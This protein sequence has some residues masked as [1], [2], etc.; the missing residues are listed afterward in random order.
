MIGIA[1][2]KNPNIIYLPWMR[3]RILKVIPDYEDPP[4]PP[5]LKREISATHSNQGRQG[6]CGRHAFSRVIVKNFFELILP[7][8]AIMN[9]AKDCNRFLSTYDLI[10]DGDLRE[11]TPKNCSFSGY[12]K[13]L[14]F[15][16]CFFLFQ[17]YISTVK[18]RPTGWLECVQVSELYQ[19]LYTS[20][21]IP[22]ITHDQLHDLQDTLYT[23]KTVQQK[24][25]I[26]LATFHFKEVTFEDIKKITDHGLY[27]ML[28]IEASDRYIDDQ[29]EQL[30]AAHFVIIVGAFVRELDGV[31]YMLIKN[32]WDSDEIYKIKF[33]QTFYL[34]SYNYDTLTDC[35]FVIPVEKPGNKDFVIP[36]QQPG[37]EIKKFDE[38]VDPYLEN[39]ANLKT[40]FN[41]IAVNVININKSCP[42]KIHE[43]VDCDADHPFR[44]QASIFHPDKTPRCTE[45]AKTKFQTLMTLKGCRRESPDQGLRLI[46]NGK[47]KSKS[48]R[49]KRMNKKTRHKKTKQKYN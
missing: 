38:V 45:E 1:L 20:I 17:T 47:R 43:P 41:S 10:L 12:I 49:S 33:G 26:S 22:K 19:H 44:Q 11:L 42:S 35:S 3:D 31:R 9:Q 21:E 29:D 2:D 5:S 24:Y 16:H 28:R 37:K 39:Y 15:L 48:K 32:S 36:L 23:L 27:I 8:R 6:V 7:L 25:G 13:I 14:L 30:H 46:G 34:S 18:E 40:K 4:F